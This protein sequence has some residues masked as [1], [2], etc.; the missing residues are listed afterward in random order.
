MFGNEVA[1]ARTALRNGWSVRLLGDR[2][3]GRSTVA[4]EV[5][6]SIEQTGATVVRCIGERAAAEQPGYTLG[7]V[8]VD[9]GVPQRARE[10]ERGLN[11]FVDEVARRISPDAV[12][13]IDD[14]H[15]IDRMSL[16]ALATIRDRLGLRALITEVTGT[17]PADRFPL[18]W[19]ERA[20]TLR[21]LDLV[22]TSALAQRVLGGHLSPSAVTRV[23][24]KTGGSPFLTTALLQSARERDLLELRS[25]TWVQ[26]GYSLWNDD[27]Y[28]IL[29]EMLVDAGEDVVAL[30]RHLAT[31]GTVSEDG[32]VERFGR[33]T[34]LR[35]EQRGFMRS[36]SSTGD[37]KMIAWPPILVDRFRRLRAQPFFGAS[38][39]ESWWGFTGDSEKGPAFARR[40]VDRALEEARD[41]YDRWTDAPT[42]GNALAYF[43]AASGDMRQQ[44]QIRRVLTA[45][46]LAADASSP[47][48][49]L[50]VAAR[51]QW[52][53]VQEHES[54]VAIEILRQYGEQYPEWMP[55][56]DALEVL[57]MITVGEGVPDDL[58]AL[59]APAPD[60]LG[61]RSAVALQ[62]LLASGRL[63][64]AHAY[65]DGIGV[66]DRRSIVWAREMLHLLDGDARG[67]L[68]SAGRAMQSEEFGLDRTRFASAAYTAALSWH[69]LGDYRALQQAVDAAVLV[70]RPVLEYTPLYTACLN[71]QGLIA[72]LTGQSAAKDSFLEE[73]M[74]L[75]PQ[76]GAF[77][78]MGADSFQSII[79]I[80]VTS[81]AYDESVAKVVR[82]RVELGYVTGAVQT[83]VASLVMAYG[84]R[85]A[86]ELREAMALRSIPA[87]RAAADL[88]LMLEYEAEPVQITSF[89]RSIG[90]GQYDGQLQSML[91]AAV[92]SARAQ[93]DED[94]AVDLELITRHA[95]GD[96]LASTP[97]VIEGI[98]KPTATRLSGRE[99]E[100]A[101]LSGTLQNREIAGRL[102][103]SVRT[104]ENHLNNALRKT[105][106]RSRA[107][108][109]A[110]VEAER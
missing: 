41:A 103:V 38:T 30:L 6:D 19:P 56:I 16:Q 52:L 101:L 35:A 5:A 29:D 54:G 11:V 58:D 106:V 9:V 107:E 26:S 10:P 27:M 91:R 34:V 100:I 17:E 12:L 95:F 79:D 64:E 22:R 1:T 15:R 89:L 60:P 98:P 83:A 88:A 21:P 80:P 31:E 65:S 42:T 75:L 48:D 67:A 110:L 66:S 74:L 24:S 44:N 85:V 96:A 87:Y 8:A 20:I 46:P 102:G 13:L 76:P 90:P 70:G 49:F 7:R 57:M 108:L 23:F 25:G 39:E 2:G 50:F 36:S 63:D 33:D 81:D 28:P 92:R 78:G 109:F 43:S 62:A 71:I 73:S 53:A 51:A 18:R 84:P 55:S 40:L 68:K 32:L 69:Y 59:L 82:R 72:A 94:R 4:R 99:R 3:S 105:E 77:L 61:I 104:V 97:D 86:A 45:T 93:G 37:S 14:Y 47:D